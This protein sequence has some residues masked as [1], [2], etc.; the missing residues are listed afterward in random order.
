MNFHK[1]KVKRHVTA[2]K[3][4]Q[5][6]GLVDVLQSFQDCTSVWPCSSSRHK[7]S[8]H[9]MRLW[10][11]YKMCCPG[12]VSH[13]LKSSKIISNYDHNYQYSYILY[14]VYLL[15][16]W[17]CQKSG[18]VVALRSET[19]LSFQPWIQRHKSMKCLS[20]H[21]FKITCRKSC[22]FLLRQERVCFTLNGFRSS[23]CKCWWM[24]RRRSVSMS[25]HNRC[26]KC[27]KDSLNKK[28]FFRKI[29][30]YCS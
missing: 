27:C 6:F 26:R 4:A 16:Q 8:S 12:S 11:S 9:A 21:Y 18:L 19:S 14:K 7:S 28:K 10:L 29:P 3:P 20:L 25:R 22:I 15:C 30:S 5:V 1:L 2:Y 23:S 24:C 13:T 17:I